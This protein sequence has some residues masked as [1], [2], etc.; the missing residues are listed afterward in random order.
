MMVVVKI[1]RTV[2]VVVWIATTEMSIWVFV[3]NFVLL[4]F[5]SSELSMIHWIMSERFESLEPFCMAVLRSFMMGS[6]RLKDGNDQ[7]S[8]RVSWNYS[9]S[10]DLTEQSRLT[11]R[12]LK[13]IVA[14]FVSSVRIQSFSSFEYS[15]YREVGPLTSGINFCT[16]GC[17]NRG[18]AHS[19]SA[20][21][22]IKLFQRDLRLR[23]VLSLVKEHHVE[24]AIMFQANT[25][26]KP[27]RV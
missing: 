2:I 8:I 1:G 13:G 11:L 17:R 3:T 9:Q 12:H 19:L 23:L 25:P 5:V 15:G 7:L 22:P 27:S 26:A 16:R 24:D 14:H 4:R 6:I 10:S 21:V 18:Y 20:P